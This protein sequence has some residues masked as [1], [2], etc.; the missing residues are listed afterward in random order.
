M[1]SLAL[2]AFLLAVAAAAPAWPQTSVITR[3]YDGSRTG[4]NLN[5]TILNTSNVNVNT[6]GKLFTYTVDGE[7]YAQPLYVPNVSIPGKG[8][9]NVVYVVTMKDVVYAFD[10]DSNAGANVSPLWSVDFR[11]PAAGITEIPIANII[12]TSTGNIS[13]SVGIESTPYIDLTTNTMYLVARTLETNAYVQRLHAL[14]ITSGAEKFGGP[15]TI[16]ASV[17]GNG[18]GSSGGTLVFDPKIENQ[19]SSLALANGLIFIAWASHAD[20]FNWH[21]WVMAYNAQ[22]LQQAGVYCSTPNGNPGGG[23][24]MAGRAPVVDSTGTVYYITGNG[25][26]NGSTSFGDS[27]LKF[28]T[29]G[30]GFSLVDWFTPDNWS[31]LNAADADL[32]SS[33]PLLVPGT[34]LLVGAGKQSIFYLLNVSNLGHE[35]T[36]N[37]QIVQLFNNHGA[38]IKSGPVYYNRATDPGPWMYVWADSDYL[39]AYHFNGA[40]FDTTPVSLSTMFV[41]GRGGA[42]LTVTANGSTPGTGI[43]WSAAPYN[44]DADGD[45]VPGIVRAF[46][47]GDLTKELWNSH[48]NLSRDDIGLWAKF[49]PPTVVN[50]KVYMGSF[51]NALAVYGPIPITP[52]FMLSASP[53]RT[54]VAPGG[55]K[56]FTINVSALNG[57]AGNVSLSVSGLPTGASA[58]F[59]PASVTGSGSATLSVTTTAS[60]PIGTST[61]TIAG[62]SGSLSNA[63]TA[64]LVITSAPATSI[65]ND[66]ITSTDAGS[67]SSIVTTAPFSTAP[68]NEL[69]LAFVATDY[70]S[71]A[72]TT[73]TSVSG[74]GLT[75]TLAVR[76][77]AQSG[78]A[79]IWRAFAPSPLNNVTVTAS[80]SQSVVSSITV[81]SFTGVDTSGTNGSGAIGATGTGNAKS[82]APTAT[83][84]TT[85][86]NSWVVGVGNDYDNPIGRTPGVG[87]ILVHQYLAPVGDTY[88]V[89]EQNA[90]T[91]LSGTTVT[92]NDTAPTSDRYNLSI[93]EILPAS[94]VNP[95]Y[96]LS[97]TISPAASGSGT[98]VTLSGAASA[99]MTA[100]SSGNYTFSG[101]ANGTSY[102]VTPTKSGFTFSPTSQPV[103][104]SGANATANFTATPVPTYSISG[105]ISPVTSGSGTTVT[106]SGAASATMTAD[107]S[108]NYTFSGLASGTSY[109]V[110]PTKSGFTF[111]PA[112]QLVPI[113]GGNVTGINF[114]AQ[115]AAITIDVTT[116]KDQGTSSNTVA[117]S[118]FS[119]KSANELLL[120][121]ISSDDTSSGTNTTVNSVAGAGL[122][123]VR[124]I[125]TNTQRGTSEIWR[126]F[127]PTVLAN[128]SVTANLSLNVNSSMTVMSF[129]GVSIT[130]TNGSGAIGA[131]GTGNANPGAPI[132]ALVTT[133]NNSLVIGVGNDWD[134]AIARTAGANQTIVHQYLAPVGDTY[135]VQRVNIPVAAG[136]IVTVNDTAPTTDRYNLSICEILPAS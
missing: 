58:S 57:F 59:S 92:I 70:V 102:T 113:S 89:Q 8:A 65:S 108:G 96:T 67:A 39:K 112:N 61:L 55:A 116:S 105:T 125:R 79:E 56:S 119:T 93:V 20:F 15:V 34:N 16:T 111:S 99:T 19:R 120:A 90:A 33:G 72:N 21:G 117:T 32:G 103:T 88:W 7:I 54:S 109:T 14:D 52:N 83:L 43:V 84:V 26:W 76:T 41:I 46:D 2:F 36:G 126:A 114:T 106:L 118:T 121:F 44:Q 98:T 10:A 17:P 85:R 133:K 68:G 66:V 136:T 51:S 94:V 27:F 75:W 53:V 73:V 11:N 12:G 40:T 4:A 86:N 42:A 62:T 24:W 30:S 37:G 124:V 135:W 82:G 77:N 122:T 101:L 115:S 45:D 80:L 123:W 9:H 129:A 81:M 132:A 22:T 78:T 110:T 128:V 71:G 48:Q 87:Q 31:A 23:I 95:T 64:T 49:N 25:D 38:D 97:G 1:K 91:P 104:I 47:A 50:G 13:G 6:F 18:S 69:L 74:G 134:N 100:D 35:Q 60:T 29:S 130:G 63:T 107:T 3:H 5:E 28:G 127:T 131:T